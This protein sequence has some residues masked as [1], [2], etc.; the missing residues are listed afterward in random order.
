MNLIIE[1]K[2]RVEAILARHTPKYRSDEFG[3]RELSLVDRLQIMSMALSELQ[4]ERN[5][6]ARSF[7]GTKLMMM[8]KDQ[9]YG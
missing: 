4:A 5:S 1:Q 3:S 7:R 9:H 6:G 2:H 8:V